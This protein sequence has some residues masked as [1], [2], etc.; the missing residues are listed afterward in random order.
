MT[1]FSVV[2]LRAARR[3]HNRM[4]CSRAL[5]MAGGVQNLC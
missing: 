5:D 4:F 1:V 2:L 3:N